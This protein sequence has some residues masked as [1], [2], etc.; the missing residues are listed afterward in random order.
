MRRRTNTLKTSLSPFSGIPDMSLTP[1]QRRTEADEE[2][3][4]EE[5]DDSM[6]NGTVSDDENDIYLLN[7]AD[8]Q[9]EG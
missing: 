4:S 9:Q 3:N 6:T 5:E 1:K 2:G 8:Y 7:Q